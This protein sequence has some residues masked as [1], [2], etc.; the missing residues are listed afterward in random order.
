M[1]CVSTKNKSEKIS[2]YF[3]IYTVYKTNFIS[4]YQWIEK[5]SSFCLI[6]ST[7]FWAFYFVNY[8]GNPDTPPPPVLS[9]LKGLGKGAFKISKDDLY[10]TF[11]RHLNL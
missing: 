11:T 2:F 6:Y 10:K 8:E 1:S 9:I 7:M 5:K 4:K 3:L